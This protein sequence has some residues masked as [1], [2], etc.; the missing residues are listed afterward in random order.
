MNGFDGLTVSNEGF[1]PNDPKSS[2]QVN[3]VLNCFVWSVDKGVPISPE[4][5]KFIRDGVAAYTAGD[6]TPW[7]GVRGKV[8]KGD[9]RLWAALIVHAHIIPNWNA[10]E[11][12]GERPSLSSIRKDANLADGTDV[13]K[14][15]KRAERYLH[16]ELNKGDYGVGRIAAEI[17]AMAKSRG[18]PDG[19]VIE[20]KGNFYWITPEQ[21]Q[22]L[23]DEALSTIGIM[24]SALDQARMLDE[25]GGIDN[26]LE[27]KYLLRQAEI[28]ADY[29][30]YERALTVLSE[31][32]S[33]FKQGC[34]TVDEYGKAVDATLRKYFFCPRW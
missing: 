18:L 10:Y 33:A 19:T 5:L 24:Q 32:E 7:K 4:M 30:R 15:L 21:S 1:V 13:S 29:V 11:G 28:D 2:E 9:P 17:M 25:Q 8:E 23:Q 20:S 31:L 12:K 27:S 34:M 3:N 22:Q 14:S 6:K 16:A 26:L